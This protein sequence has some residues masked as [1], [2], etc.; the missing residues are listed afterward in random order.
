MAE[1]RVHIYKSKMARAYDN[2]VR[3]RGFKEGDLVLR[4]TESAGPVGKQDAKW[5]DPYVVTEVIGPGPYRLKSGDGKPLPRTWNV[6]N[7][8]KYYV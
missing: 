8:K 2:K 7:L 1:R 6:K 4:K 5:D 3:P